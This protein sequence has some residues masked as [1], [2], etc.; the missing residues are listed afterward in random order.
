MQ[1]H[2]PVSEE[3]LQQPV[4][5]NDIMK[6]LVPTHRPNDGKLDSIVK[7]HQDELAKKVDKMFREVGGRRGIP[8]GSIGRI[9]STY[10]EYLDVEAIRA[11][12]RMGLFPPPTDEETARAKAA[13]HEL[14]ESDI[15][16]MAKMGTVLVMRLWWFVSN[17]VEVWRMQ[18]KIKRIYK[19]DLSGG[20]ARDIIKLADGNIQLIKGVEFPPGFSKTYLEEIREKIEIL[21]KNSMGTRLIEATN[22]RTA[23]HVDLDKKGKK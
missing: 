5:V 10:L 20:S 3:V 7:N 1:P 8:T 16:K 4:Q 17:Y 13:Y 12:G 22:Q 6:I 14:H 2:V 21:Q 19:S 23:V 15:E 18:E 9:L 11:E